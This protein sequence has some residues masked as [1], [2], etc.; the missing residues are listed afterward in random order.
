MVL[1]LDDPQQQLSPAR[2][3]LPHQY[4][5]L[6]SSDTG[7]D[8]R[9]NGLLKLLYVVKFGFLPHLRILYLSDNKLQ[10]A[11]VLALDC[12][13]QAVQDRSLGGAAHWLWVEEEGV[14]SRQRAFQHSCAG[15]GVSPVP[16]S[17]GRRAG[18]EVRDSGEE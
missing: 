1:D 12:A 11:S 3:A 15:A 5:T 9:D 13:A 16:A 17:L 18:A 14:M 6:F 2:R 4:G 10:D 7:N 8:L